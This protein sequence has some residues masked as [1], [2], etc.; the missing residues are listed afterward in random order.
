MYVTDREGG[1]I[2]VL[3]LRWDPWVSWR[4]PHPASSATG[5]MRTVM[6]IFA[7]K[8]GFCYKEDLPIG[9]DFGVQLENGS[10]SGLIGELNRGEADM[11]MVPMSVIHIRHQAV[12]FSE[13][14]FV[15]EHRITF[16]RPVPEGDIAGFVKPFT[17]M[18]WLLLLFCVLGV[19]AATFLIQHGL[20]DAV[21]GKSED[22]D[23]T[24]DS[25]RN[26]TL[27]KMRYAVLWT[28]SCLFSQPV[29]REP[30]DVSVRIVAGMWLL[31]CLIVGTV[32]RSNLK[33]MLILP[34]VVLPFST[35][36]EFVDADVRGYIITGGIVDVGLRGMPANTT[37]GKIR[38]KSRIDVNVGRGIKELIE[39][40][41]APITATTG[42]R[43]VFHYDFTNEGHCRL[44]SSRDGVFST[45]VALG[46][47]KGSRLKPKVDFMIRGL[48]EFGIMQ[49]LFERETPNTTYCFGKPVS[50]SPTSVDLRPLV[51][52]DFYGILCLYLGGIMLASLVFFVERFSNREQTAKAE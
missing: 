37:L 17:P 13:P 21:R 12:D 16:K 40:K 49:H 47:P 44:Y 39:G 14:L 10:F 6:N 33:A 42:Q 11:S 29:P 32:Y 1:C 52:Q 8:I 27:S 31:S 9:L 28:V 5:V 41:I 23:G 35:F 50:I 25:R 15:D 20:G 48:K 34:K 4:M 19:C 43:W 30:R 3:L 7:E 22:G 2:R 38:D 46:F 18:M 24:P 36:E 45:S 26:I 51:L